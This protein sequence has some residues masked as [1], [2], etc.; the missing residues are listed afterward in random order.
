MTWKLNSERP[1]YAQIIEKVVMD[2]ISGL[3]RPGEKLPSVRELAM[4]AE[5]NPNTMQKALAELERT[6]LVRSHRTSGRFITEDTDLIMDEKRKIAKK[7]IQ[8]FRDKM[9]AIGL[10]TE[11]IVQLM[12]EKDTA[13]EEEEK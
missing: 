12:Y 6:G 8:D 11:E 5:V 1:I 9:N 3:Y 13:E 7:E 2:I 10:T 4:D